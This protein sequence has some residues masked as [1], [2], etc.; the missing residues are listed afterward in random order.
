MSKDLRLDHSLA[1]SHPCAT[2][3]TAPAIHLIARDPRESVR[4]T[5]PIPLASNRIALV[6]Y[7]VFDRLSKASSLMSLGLG[8]SRR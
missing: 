5:Y 2:L 1:A 3:A 7:K 8:Y 6:A 4:S